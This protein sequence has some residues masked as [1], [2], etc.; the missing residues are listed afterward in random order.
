[1]ENTISFSGA[2]GLLCLALLAGLLCEY[3]PYDIQQNW[4]N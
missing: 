2:P 3:E 1:M 4:I